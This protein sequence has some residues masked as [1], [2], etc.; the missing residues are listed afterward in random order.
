MSGTRD[1]TTLLV[2]AVDEGGSV[3][4]DAVGNGDAFDVVASVRIGRNLMRFVDA[5][6]LFVSVR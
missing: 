1:A 2:L 6:D 5:C 4:I 3:P